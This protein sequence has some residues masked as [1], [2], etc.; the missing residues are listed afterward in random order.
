MHSLADLYVESSQFQ[1]ALPL[2]VQASALY[3]SLRLSCELHQQLW[4]NQ[5][6]CYLAL[7][8]P[9]KAQATLELALS[10]PCKN[11]LMRRGQYEL[12]VQVL[13]VQNVPPGDQ[14]VRQYN[15]ARERIQEQTDHKNDGPPGSAQLK[16]L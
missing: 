8:Q 3:D 7:K 14:R 5:A 13:A 10:S 2:Y 11:Q 16:A 4:Y 1:K 6:R 15:A 12:M 9:Q